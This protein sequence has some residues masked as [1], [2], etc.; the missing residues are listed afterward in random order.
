MMPTQIFKPVQP[1][2]GLSSS[3]GHRNRY[4]LQG[5]DG[6]YFTD[7]PGQAGV[8]STSDPTAAHAFVDVDA[9]AARA[10]ALRANGIAV[11]RIAAIGLP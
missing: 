11:T 3:M 9:A 5:A 2:I 4:L 8:Y 7:L 1:S 10:Q 6:N